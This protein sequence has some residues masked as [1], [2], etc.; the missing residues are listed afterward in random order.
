MNE[1]AAERER[2]AEED[3]CRDQEARRLAVDVLRSTRRACVRRSALGGIAEAYC[4]RATPYGVARDLLDQRS[5]RAAAVLD[6]MLR[7]MAENGGPPVAEHPSVA[8]VIGLLDRA[9]HQLT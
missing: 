3:F 4:T 9:I 7:G 5:Q 8:E 2:I 6:Y 1:S